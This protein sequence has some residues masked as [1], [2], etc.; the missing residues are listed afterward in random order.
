[1]NINNVINPGQIGHVHITE[2]GVFT[3]EAIAPTGEKIYFAME[4]L[5]NDKKK[6]NKYKTE[7]AFLVTGGNE[8]VGTIGNLIDIASRINDEV[9]LNEF[10][11]TSTYPDFWTSDQQRFEYLK[12]KLRNRNIEADSPKGKELLT[13]PNASNGVNV[14]QQTHMVYISKSPICNR[15]DFVSLSSNTGFGSYVDSYGHLILSVGVMINLIKDI[16][17]NRGIF[18]NPWSVIEGGYGGLSMMAHSFTCMVIEDY[19]SS[20]QTFKVRPFKKMAEIFVNSLPKEQI[21]VNGIRGDLYDGGFE[22][23]G[24]VEVLVPVK[25]LAD[26]HR[27]K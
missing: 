8:W 24:E 27:A 15:A 3:A 26:L 18:R 1:M 2:D 22:F 10:L 17:E 23:E 9:A 11:A 16:V 20:V 4:S 13:I 5:G 7:A 21:T 14:S 19:F 6:W 25:I 12:E